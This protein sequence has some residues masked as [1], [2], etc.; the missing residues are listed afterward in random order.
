MQRWAGNGR[1]VLSDH[2]LFTAYN[3][4]LHHYVY[5]QSLEIDHD[6]QATNT[7]DSGRRE[8]QHDDVQGGKSH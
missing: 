5:I 4:I 3:T 6:D 1:Q 2:P 7:S 8:I